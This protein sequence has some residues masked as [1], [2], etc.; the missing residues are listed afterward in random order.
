M[1]RINHYR[2]SSRDF[3]IDM[4]VK[5]AGFSI[6]HDRYFCQCELTN[7]SQ[8]K[9]LG[10]NK[11]NLCFYEFFQSEEAIALVIALLMD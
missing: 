11:V 2:S 3:D 7:D 8:E 9:R 1:T 6:H 4:Y 5:D 10:E